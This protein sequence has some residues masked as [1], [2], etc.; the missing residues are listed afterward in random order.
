MGESTTP[1]EGSRGAAVR[2]IAVVL[3]LIATVVAIG[4]RAP[5]HSYAYAQMRQMGATLGM[6]ESNNNDSIVR[7]DLLDDESL[8]TYDSRILPLL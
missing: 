2:D 5:G 7:R 4:V 1:G 6:I 3:T 8:V